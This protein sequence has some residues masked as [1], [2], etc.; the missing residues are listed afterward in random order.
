MIVRERN[1]E[2][3]LIEQDNH[4]V[5]SADLMESW[6]DSLFHGKEYKQSVQYAIRYHDHG[7][8]Y[9]DKQ[10]FWDERSQAPFTFSNYPLLPK[11]VIYTYGI[12]EVE[13]NDPYAALLCSRHYSRFLLHDSS[14][15]AVSFIN[16]E[17]KRQKRI[18]DFLGGVNEKLVNFHYGLLKLGD[19]LSL[20]MC[21]NEPGVSKEKEHFFFRNGITIPLETV[22]EKQVK[23][24]IKWRDQQIISASPFPFNNAVTIRIKQ[25]VI[26]KKFIGTQGLIEHYVN[27]PYEE[28][29][30]DFVQG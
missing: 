13:K 18:I 10:P 19:D 24:N 3:I 28:L 5:I 17:N 22:E 26:S 16:Q 8:T 2:F 21:L 1:D 15:E 23:M 20:Y 4:A 27:A 29:R 12:D 9:F 7:W 14:E 30:L 6:S 25:K 11:L